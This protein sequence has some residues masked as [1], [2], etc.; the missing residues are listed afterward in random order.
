MKK[1]RR[2]YQMYGAVQG[3]GFRYTAYYAAERFGITGFVENEYD[4]SVTLVVQG[5]ET[6]I[7]QMLQMIESSRYIHIRSFRVKEL[8]VEEEERS[9]YVNY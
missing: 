3:V 6:A 2:R 9:F 1:I 5:T 8:P 7:A 4:G